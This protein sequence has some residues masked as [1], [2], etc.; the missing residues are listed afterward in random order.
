MIHA[1]KIF[2]WLFF[3]A[4][5][6]S[7]Y[8]QQEPDLS[9]DPVVEVPTF[10]GKGPVVGIDGGHNN[11]HQLDGGFAPFAK[12]LEADGFS[13]KAVSE[14]TEEE[15]K[16]LDIF[17]IANPLHE[18][19]VGN[20]KN[21]VPS[22]FTEREIN[23]LYDWVAAGGRLLVIADHMPYGGAADQLARK[24]GFSYENGFVMSQPQQW[25]PET[26]RKRDGT[27]NENVLTAGLD[28]LAGFTGSAL[29]CPENAISLGRFPATH[30]LLL[31][32]VAWQFNE[33]TVRQKLDVFVPGAL[34]EMRAGRVAFFT[35]ASMFTAQIVQD[36]Y[37]VGFNS[38][39]APHNQ[40]F[41]LNVMHWLA[42]PPDPKKK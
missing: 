39:K 27:L 20:W 41:V 8:G 36:K 42:G 37:K 26:Y 38:P 9:F 22:A 40:Q 10:S 28:S 2:G 12:L 1:K 17:V 15:F 29:Q 35:E 30:Q 31:P 18:S 23:L 5:L 14:M 11:L 34:L 13:M 25:P 7:M 3:S 4:I 6:V 24:F 16:G 21:P 19:N 32:E 33:N